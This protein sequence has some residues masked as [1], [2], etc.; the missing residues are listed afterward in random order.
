MATKPLFRSLDDSSSEVTIEFDGK[1][2]NVPDGIN[3][4]AALLGAGVTP[5]RKTPVSDSPRTAYCMMGV[6]FECLVLIDGVSRQACQ[7]RTEA[8]LKVKSHFSDVLESNP[9]V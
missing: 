9:D 1:L 2:I 6:C 5:T 8:G 7:V 3:L 4:A